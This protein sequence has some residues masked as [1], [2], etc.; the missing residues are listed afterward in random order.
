[1]ITITPEQILPLVNVLMQMFAGVITVGFAI[2]IG[3]AVL[4]LV[5]R[6]MGR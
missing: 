5:L 1:M 3:G 4:S 6:L 2:V